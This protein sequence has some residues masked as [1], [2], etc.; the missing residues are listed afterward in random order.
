MLLYKD[1][2]PTDVLRVPVV[3]F[4]SADVPNAALSAAVV[5]LYKEYVPLAVLFEPVVLLERA[6]RPTATLLA[7]SYTHLKLPTIYSV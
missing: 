6:D 3:L 2:L 4:C 1:N 7:V 5:F